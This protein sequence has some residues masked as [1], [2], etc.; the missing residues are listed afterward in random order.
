MVT[1]VL[2]NG[3][4]TIKVGIVNKDEQ[5]RLVYLKTLCHSLIFG[6]KNQIRIIPNAVIRSKGDK[7]TYFG[8]ELTQCKDYSSLHYRLPFEKVWKFSYTHFL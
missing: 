6:K 8:H 4:S 1:I 2:D 5:P 3:A 7:S